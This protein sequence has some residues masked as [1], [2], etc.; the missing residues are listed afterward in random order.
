MYKKWKCVK[1][2]ITQVY[3]AKLIVTERDVHRQTKKRPWLC[4]RPIR[5]LIIRNC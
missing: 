1:K 3:T 4:V 5:Y 2:E